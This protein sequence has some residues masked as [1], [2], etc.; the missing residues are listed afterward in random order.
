MTI[1]GRDRLQIV[2]IEQTRLRASAAAG[3]TDMMARLGQ[4]RRCWHQFERQDK[5][6]FVRW[7]MRSRRFRLSEELPDGTDGTGC[8]DCEG[9]SIC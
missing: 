4:A 5:P 7:R 1:L 2:W 8:G 9:L 3:C 6:A